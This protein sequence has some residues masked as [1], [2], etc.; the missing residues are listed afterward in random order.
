MER[1]LELA[2]RMEAE[3]L[4]FESYASDFIGSYRKTFTDHANDQTDLAKLGASFRKRQRTAQDRFVDLH[5]AMA[6][7]LTRSEWA[8]LSKQEAA[9]V[10]QLLAPAAGG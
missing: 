5:L 2:G 8:V 4:E 9:I 3:L 6:N 1:Y 7:T 10:E